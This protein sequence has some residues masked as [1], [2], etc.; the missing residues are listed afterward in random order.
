MKTIFITIFQGAEAKNILRTDVYKNLIVREDTRLVF[1]VDSPERA[2]YYKKEFSHPRVVY[3]AVADNSHKGLDAFFSSLSFLLLR[4]KTTD[5][6]REMAVEENKNYIGHFLSVILNLILARPLFRKIARK[7]DYLLVKD[8]AFAKYFDQYNP[9]V[10]FLAHLF[11]GQEINLLRE[12]KRRGV[13]SVGFINSWDKLTARRSLRLL[14]DSLIVFNEIVKKEAIKYADMKEKNIIIAGIPNYDWH[15]NYKPISKEEFCRRN[16]LDPNKKIIVYA[17]MGKTFSNSDWDIIDLL[18]NSIANNLMPD[19]QLFVRFQP[20]DFAEEE[21]LKKR[22]WL[23]YDLPGVRFSR[24]RGVNWDMSFDD[25]KG[26]TDTLANASLFIC[27]ASSISIDAAV[28]DVPV[29]NIDF[30]INE[31]EL[32]SKSPTFFYKTYHYGNVV[33]SG[34]VRLPKSKDELISWINKYLANPAIDREARKKLVEA[35]CWKLDGNSGRRIAEHILSRF[36]VR[37]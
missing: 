4:T 13:Q 5:L 32:L 22:P 27:Y 35:Q 6:R 19:S 31:K 2:E 24:T 23:R 33:S 26:L 10:V 3:E 34:G 29:I 12:A 36:D 7:L 18:N 16:N 8:K 30:E 21:E 17:P 15:I 1:F 25:I 20:N 9:D 14:P 28:F 37:P 11:D